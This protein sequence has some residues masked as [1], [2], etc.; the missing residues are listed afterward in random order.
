MDRT[1]ESS[2]NGRPFRLT[3]LQVENALRKVVPDR[4]HVHA[5]ECISRSESEAVRIAE[6]R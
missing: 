1:Y 4:I 3:V 6:Q 5:V 2:L